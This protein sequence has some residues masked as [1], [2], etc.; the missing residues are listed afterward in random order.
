MNFNNKRLGLWVN[1]AVQILFL[2][3]SIFLQNG[4]VCRFVTTLDTVGMI[5]IWL[6]M[7]HFEAWVHVWLSP[8]AELLRVSFLQVSEGVNLTEHAHMHLLS[9][10]HTP[11]SY[12]T[13]VGFV[14]VQIWNK[15]QHLDYS[16]DGQ[17]LQHSLCVCVVEICEKR[18]CDRPHAKG[19]FLKCIDSIGLALV[20]NL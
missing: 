16:S 1:I 13:Q 5:H 9:C 14:Q 10:S 11:S 2:V 4:Q 12:V 17:V 15:E 19:V 7:K 6:W 8:M 20:L 3:A 18:Q